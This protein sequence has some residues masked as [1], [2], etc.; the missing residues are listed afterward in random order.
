MKNPRDKKGG[1]SIKAED[2]E[3]IIPQDE[4]EEAFLKIFEMEF[5]GNF[6]KDP[7]PIVNTFVSQ[8]ENIDKIIEEATNFRKKIESIIPVERDILR[9]AV[10]EL[11]MGKDINEVLGKA[12]RLSRRYSTTNSYRFI[13]AVIINAKKIVESKSKPE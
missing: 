7:N 8:K 13:K 10:S 6:H 2:I 4:S 12:V 3:G 1:N 11:L 9:V 5:W